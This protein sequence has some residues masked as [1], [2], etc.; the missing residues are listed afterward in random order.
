MTYA[1]IEMGGKQYRVEKG[2]S[3][4]VD[5]VDAKEGAK[6]TARAVLYAAGDKT[7]MD[8]PELDKV[9]VEAVVTEH[10]KGDKIRVFK[11]RPKKRYKRTVGHRSLLTRLE[12]S[13]IRTGSARA[14]ADEKPK[15]DAEAEKPKAEAAEPK[16]E[17]AK[18]KAETAKPKAET[19]KA[20]TEAAKPKA[21]AKPKAEAAKPKA[22]KPAAAKKKA[23]ANK[24]APKKPAA[25]KKDS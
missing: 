10:I 21:P 17:A 4:V 23:P 5:R 24:A 19:A 11:Y 1:V 22:A 16:A 6:V 18:A 2:D 25:K 20:K 12:I 8:G 14:K 13:D 9:K 3:V 15:A 7:V